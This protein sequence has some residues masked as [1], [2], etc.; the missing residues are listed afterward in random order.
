MERIIYFDTHVLIWLY[1]GELNLFS[2][3]SK[4]LIESCELLISP[5]VSLE[6]KYLMEIKKITVKPD[7]IINQLKRTIGIKICSK[8][9][10]Q[11]I[12]ESIKHDWTR[13]P[14][15]RI[16]TAQ[17]SVSNSKLLTKDRFILKHYKKAVWE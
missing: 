7:T 4:E 16:I 12:E 8:R 17:A 2:K 1:S 10:E 5:I 3:K 6:L 9:F 15:D 13:D 11:V 14:F